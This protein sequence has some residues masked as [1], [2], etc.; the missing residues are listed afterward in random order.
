M[1]NGL[2]LLIFFVATSAFAVDPYVKADKKDKDKMDLY[3]GSKQSKKEGWDYIGE[4]KNPDEPKQYEKPIRPLWKRKID[5]NELPYKYIEKK[6][7]ENSV[8][9]NGSITLD[10]MGL[11]GLSLDV[12]GLLTPR[13]TGLF[14]DYKMTRTLSNGN[15]L[16]GFIQGRKISNR[17]N[18]S[19]NAEIR[20]KNDLKQGELNGSITFGLKD[21]KYMKKGYLAF[22]A[23]M[24]GKDGNFRYYR[25]SGKIQGSLK[26]ANLNAE[27]IDVDGKYMGNI[28]G[29]F[30]NFNLFVLPE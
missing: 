26:L 16:K 11:E 12:G 28:K 4:G 22:F 25:I 13:V 20:D 17:I 9:K 23:R 3:S 7:S 10:I 21:K 24:R 2:L 5:Y 27:V 19:I 18:F 6:Y 30:E 1:K 15:I 8:K 29:Q 14:Y